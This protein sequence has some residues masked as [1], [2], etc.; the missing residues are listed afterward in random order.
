M[1]QNADALVKLPLSE[2]YMQTATA[3][4]IVCVR[5]ND[6]GIKWNFLFIIQTV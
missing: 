3:Q 5:S 4:L 2:D 6:F 1:L